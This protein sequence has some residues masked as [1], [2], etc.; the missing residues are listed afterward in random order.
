MTKKIILV[1]TILF[2]LYL[3]LDLT[4]LIKHKHFNQNCSIC[5]TIK[6][7]IFHTNTLKSFFILIKSLFITWFL[8]K[9]PFKKIF[10]PFTLLHQKVQLNL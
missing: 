6:N 9:I 7:R 10:F 4:L 2:I 3:I 5:L 8:I 1:I